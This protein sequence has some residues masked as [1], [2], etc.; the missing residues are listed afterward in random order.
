VNPEF[1][2]PAEE[3]PLVGDASKANALLGWQ[4]ST[5]LEKI[6][7]FMVEQDI[8]RVFGKQGY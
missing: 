7:Q 8:A 5:E 4:A 6:V 1:F 2:R 3:T